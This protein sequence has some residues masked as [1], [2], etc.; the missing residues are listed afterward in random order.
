MMDSEQPVAGLVRLDHGGFSLTTTDLPASRWLNE[1]SSGYTAGRGEDTEMQSTQTTPLEH[2]HTVRIPLP[3]IIQHTL[4]N[5]YSLWL[6]EKDFW[7]LLPHKHPHSSLKAAPAEGTG[8]APPPDQRILSFCQGR[9]KKNK[10]TLL[11]WIE[12]DTLVMQQAASSEAMHRELVI[13][14]TLRA[15]ENSVVKVT[16]Y[17][18]KPTQSPE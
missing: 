18:L 2:T 7:G 8:T 15:A 16:C 17:T 4:H 5:S 10:K 3:A 11:R 9:L 13:W 1:T 14:G 6:C 12:H